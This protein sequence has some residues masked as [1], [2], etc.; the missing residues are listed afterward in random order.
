MSGVPL[1]RGDGTEDVRTTAQGLD[2]RW[3][4]RVGAVVIVVFGNRPEVGLAALLLGALRRVYTTGNA[5]AVRV[6]SPDRSRRCCPARARPCRTPPAPAV[7][8]EVL[9]QGRMALAAA[10]ARSCCRARRWWWDTARSGPNCASGC[11]A[12]SCSR[13]ARKERRVRRAGRGS[14]SSPPDHRSSRC[15]S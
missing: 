1:P 15:G 6:D 4:R 11:R 12:G 5:R 13:L 14:A 10:P 3:R 7:L 9:R 2:H 8:R